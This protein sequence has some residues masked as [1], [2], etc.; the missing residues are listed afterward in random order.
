LLTGVELLSG[1]GDISH[2]QTI[3]KA[4]KEFDAY[5][6]RELKQLESDFDRAVKQLTQTKDK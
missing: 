5:R 6:T 1:K 4:E 2:K 3:E